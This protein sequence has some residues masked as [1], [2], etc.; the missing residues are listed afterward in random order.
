[1]TSWYYVSGS[2]RVGPIEDTD[3]QNLF[4][5]NT[6]N[7]ESYVWKAGFDNWKK[8]SEVSELSYLTSQAPEEEK[9]PS[10]DWDNLDENEKVIMIKI[11]A[12]RNSSPVEYGPFSILELKRAI[13]E[14]RISE[15]TYIFTPGMDTWAFLG[16]LENLY[17]RLTSFLPPI[18]EE[19]ER[20][21]S[22]RRPFVA[23]M[24]YHDNTVLFEGICR[25]ISTGGLQ[26]LVANPKVHVGDEV[27]F[28]VHPE[29][30]EHSFTASGEV[31]R[32]LEGNRGFSLRFM[33]LGIDA[34]NAIND[35]IHLKN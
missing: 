15:K 23:R 22:T 28:N 17:Q 6:L 11:G 29:N 9:D 33:E 8:I 16:E 4:N 31:V 20:R 27:T 21:R 10:F 30:R 3:L 2:D 24:L 7:Q 34:V 5:D 13:A 12:D 35:Y 26:I 1:M 14:K 18:I 32:I 25:D 19:E